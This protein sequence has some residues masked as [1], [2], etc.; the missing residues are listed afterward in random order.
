MRFDA[1]EDFALEMDRTDPLAAFR[2]KFHIPRDEHGQDLIYF[3]GHSLGLQ[4]LS[5]RTEV[6]RELDRWAKL[7]VAG[8]FRGELPWIRYHES[9]MPSMADLVGATVDEIV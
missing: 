1:S 5:A 9:I 3:V 7:G 4:P 8:H 2:S 6:G